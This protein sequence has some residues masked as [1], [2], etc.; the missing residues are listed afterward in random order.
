MQVILEHKSGYR[1]G[2][3]EKVIEQRLLLCGQTPATAALSQIQRGRVDVRNAD[4]VVGTLPFIKAALR[5]HEQPMPEDNAYPDVLSDLLYRKVERMPLYQLMSEVDRGGSC[6]VK[7]ADR[8]KLFTGF[9][10][11]PGGDY[12]IKHVPRRE[13]VWRS[14]I[15]KWKVEWRFYVVCGQI[16]AKAFYHGDESVMPDAAVVYEAVERLTAVKG[17]PK[18]YAID[19]GVL[20][21]GKTALVECNDGF[22]IGAYE[23]VPADVYFDMLKGRWDELMTYRQEI[24]NA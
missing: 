13:M 9:V 20:D 7:P 12:W 3:E 21:D 4:L 6:F 16:K 18:H 19:F 24:A 22:A 14:D 2:H 5:Q 10:L 11:R 23:G 15:V 8:A 17:F 1:L